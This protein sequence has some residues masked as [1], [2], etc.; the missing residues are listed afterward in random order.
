MLM[1][2]SNCHGAGA[3]APVDA[4]GCLSYLKSG[5]FP[6]YSTVYT[7]WDEVRK[8]VLKNLRT[9]R[10]SLANIPPKEWPS[11]HEVTA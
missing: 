7:D 5:P 1:H 8:L 3:L 9:W 11:L 4:L 10:L 6:G 2:G